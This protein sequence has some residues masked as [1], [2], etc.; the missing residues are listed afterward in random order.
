MNYYSDTHK[1]FIRLRHILLLLI[2][3]FI[4]APMALA[5]GPKGHDGADFNAFKAAEKGIKLYDKLL[6]SG[7]IEESWE[8]NLKNIEIF[9]RQIKER[10]ELVVKFSRSKGEPQFLYIFFTENGDYSGSNF[11]GE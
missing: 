5:H 2:M 3:V 7:R 8:T 4:S 11:T 1:S 6:A 9:Q 10:K